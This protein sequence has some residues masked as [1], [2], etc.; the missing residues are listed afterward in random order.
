MNTHVHTTLMS[1]CTNKVK[2]AY[3][4]PFPIEEEALS[5][6]PVQECKINRFS[7]LARAAKDHFTLSNHL[8][9]VISGIIGGTILNVTFWRDNLKEG[10]LFIDH[11]IDIMA[12][13]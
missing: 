4:L 3:R 2:L 6:L 7:Q 1:S 9:L 8:S 11:C 13:D 12:P 10:I 5:Q